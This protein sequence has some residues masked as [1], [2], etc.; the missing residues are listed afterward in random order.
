MC[1]SKQDAVLNDKHFL[2]KYPAETCSMIRNDPVHAKDRWHN[3]MYSRLFGFT[4]VFWIW[5]VLVN[6]ITE[7][8]EAVLCLKHLCVGIASEYWR[9]Y[10]LHVGNA[11]L[12]SKGK[13]PLHDLFAANYPIT[14][15]YEMLKSHLIP[16]LT[17]SFA[18]QHARRGQA[19]R[20]TRVWHAHEYT[21]V[22]KFRLTEKKAHHN[23]HY[24]RKT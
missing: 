4:Y 5:T 3:C 10:K 14:K 6:E 21:W 2:S 8:P 20:G 22:K 17:A 15:D 1:G 12:F 16:R 24:G 18:V 7:L 9:S 23:C 13:V 11:S 19:V